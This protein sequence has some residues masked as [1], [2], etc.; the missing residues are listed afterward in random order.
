MITKEEASK[1]IHK[2]KLPYGPNIFLSIEIPP[3]KK[4]FINF[5]TLEREDEDTWIVVLYEML[6]KNYEIE[7]ENPKRVKA[8]EIKDHRPA[9]IVTAFA[10]KVKFYRG[11]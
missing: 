4:R 11:E 10:K 5:L 9:K 8:F 6:E 7:D 3:Q 2:N 1:I